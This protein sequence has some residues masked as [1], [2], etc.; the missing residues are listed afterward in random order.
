MEKKL[1]PENMFKAI[2]EFPE[3]LINALELGNSIKL[4]N[5]YNNINNIVIAGMG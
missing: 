5:N 2:W 4:K 1:D 3:N